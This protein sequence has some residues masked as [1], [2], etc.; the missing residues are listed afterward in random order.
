MP[1][2]SI[3]SL[4]REE[5]EK[6]VQEDKTEVLLKKTGFTQCKR[7]SQWITPDDSK[8]SEGLCSLTTFSH[9]L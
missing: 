2:F 8:V 3:I 5:G 4:K 1:E 7:N 9:H 6:V